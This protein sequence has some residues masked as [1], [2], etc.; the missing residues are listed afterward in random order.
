[1]PSFAD[2]KA[3]L[4]SAEASDDNAKLSLHDAVAVRDDAVAVL[5]AEIAFKSKAKGVFVKIM[6]QIKK[7]FF[8]HAC[9]SEYSFILFAKMSLRHCVSVVRT[10][11]QTVA[12]GYVF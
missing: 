8:Q 6:Y 2:G 7:N 11:P 10:Y 9:F 3:S 12:E 4:A 5:E 1:M